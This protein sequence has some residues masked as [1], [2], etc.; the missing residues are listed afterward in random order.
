M[1]STESGGRR[2][3]LTRLAAMPGQKRL[4][5]ALAVAAT[6][7]A[8]SACGS[9]SSSDQTIDPADANELTSALSGVESAVAS[10]NCRRAQTE[11]V[12]FVAVVNQL[13][14]TVGTA[15]KEALRSAGENLQTLAQDPSQCK[16]TPIGTSGPQGDQ[17]TGTS[18]T[19][20][21]ITPTTTDTTTTS[22]TSEE[23]PPSNNGGGNQ[24]GGNTG[25]GPPTGTPPGQTGGGGEPGG[26]GGAAG[27]GGGT[28]SGGTGVGGGGSD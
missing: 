6:A 4:A 25:G 10:G 19:T 15:N 28:G 16:P 26:G 11:A 12:D 7:V 20:T 21:A 3:A 1:R 5:G 17:S 22:S 13:P 9:S 27:G 14:D 18:T 8:I 23:P 24:G 2:N